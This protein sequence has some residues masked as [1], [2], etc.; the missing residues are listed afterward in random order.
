[1][2]YGKEFI[3]EMFWRHEEVDQACRVLDKL[4]KKRMKVKGPKIKQ[5]A[6]QIARQSEEV[7]A[8]RKQHMPLVRPT[9]I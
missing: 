6:R 9:F 8:L 5:L 3:V 7:K 1:M 2:P 4:I